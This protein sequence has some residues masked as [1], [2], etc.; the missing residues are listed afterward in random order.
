M[1]SLKS[2]ARKGLTSIGFGNG[3]ALNR[4]QAV[5]WNNGDPIHWHIF[6]A[7]G[8]DELRI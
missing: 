5:I 2:L 3:L 1:F 8:G 6:A 7:L 4:W